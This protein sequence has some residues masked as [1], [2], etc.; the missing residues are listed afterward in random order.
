MRDSEYAAMFHAE[1]KHWWYK[2]LRE[3]V[4]YWIA[5]HL[6]KSPTKPEIKLP[7]VGCGTGGMLLCLQQRFKNLKGVG[8]DYYDLPLYFAKQAASS[9]LIRADAKKMPFCHGV[10]DFITCLDVLYTREVFP[11][12]DHV[13]DDMR[14]LLTPQGVL[15]LQVPAFKALYGQHDANIHGA[16]RFTAEEIRS[17]LQS[18][19]FGRVVVYYR[20]NLLFS[21]AWIVR[22]IWRRKTMGSEVATPPSLINFLLYKYFKCESGLNKRMRIPF[23]L[24]VFAVAYRS[25]A[26]VLTDDLLMITFRLC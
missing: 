21:M 5:S 24:S 4:V 15:I 20:Y 25:L 8:V 19:G 14:R 22:K 26:A 10:F 23:G 9:S 2:N 6:R 11:A 16:H 7:D 13:L 3:E 17:G 1:S 18:A 12:F